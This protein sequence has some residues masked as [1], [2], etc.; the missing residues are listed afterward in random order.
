[1]FRLSE[2]LGYYSMLILWSGSMALNAYLCWHYNFV[3]GGISM[4]AYWIIDGFFSKPWTKLFAVAY[5]LA[6][7]KFYHSILDFRAAS[8]E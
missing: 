2:L 1:V 3:V 8:D 5:G 4:E 7:C 6:L